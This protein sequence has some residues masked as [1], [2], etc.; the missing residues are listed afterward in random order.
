MSASS[1]ASILRMGLAGTPMTSQPAGTILHQRPGA[2]LSALLHD[3]AVQDDGADADAHV[4]HDP[5]GV[6]DGAMADRD[7]VA[8]DARKLRRHVEHG[9]VRHVRV[10]AERHVVVLV[11]PQDGEGPDRGA[12]PDRHVA[13]H[14]VSLERIVLPPA[15]KGR[16]AGLY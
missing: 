12:G 15:V 14:D 9:I 11:A 8:D 5:T 4:V 3:R 6:Y 2:H 1:A 10:A 7:V 13:D 16:R